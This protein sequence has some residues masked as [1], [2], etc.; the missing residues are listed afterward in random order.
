MLTPVHFSKRKQQ[1]SDSRQAV[2]SKSVICVVGQSFQTHASKDIIFTISP[3][4]VS[5]ISR[6]Q[7]ECFSE[8]EMQP[9]LRPIKHVKHFN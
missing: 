1:L 4:P 9:A 2:V 3:L 8:A 6:T 5:S 7:P